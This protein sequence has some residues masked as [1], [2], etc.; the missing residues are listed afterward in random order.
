M[1]EFIVKNFPALGK[2]KRWLHAMLGT[3][4]GQKKSYSQHQEDVFLYT[5]LAKYNLQNGIYVDVGANHPVSI[6]N[7]FWFYRQGFHGLIVEPN[8]ELANLFRK[9]RPRDIVANVG[10]GKEAIFQK[11]YFSKSPVIS[12]FEKES[13]DKLTQ[14]SEDAIWGVSYLPILP[15]DS[16][17]KN[18]NP[19][20]IFFL[21]IDVEGLDYD[22]LLGATETLKK[23]L[24]LVVEQN[25]DEEKQ[26]I[27]QIT[28]QHGFEYVTD[29]SCNMIFKNM[30]SK[31]NKY[32][33]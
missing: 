23:V 18:I 14:N 30:D 6:S 9:F 10:C 31:F 8:E 33:K 21:S 7:S 26:K 5:Q 4:Q 24:W 13:I 19:E 16:I 3:T 11:F 32:L 29:I 12:S 20:W 1:K 17:L 2:V 15:L 27:Q 25:G 22:V 28:K